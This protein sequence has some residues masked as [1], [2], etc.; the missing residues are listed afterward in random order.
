MSIVIA[1]QLAKSF[2]PQDLFW[3]L[4]FSVARGDRVALVG[5]NGTGKTTLLR[6]L[7]GLEQPTSGRVHRARGLRIGYLPQGASLE[8]DGTLWQAIMAGFEALRAMEARLHELE[9]RMADPASAEEALEAYAPL[10][11]RFEAQGGYS[12]QDQARRVLMGLGFPPEEHEMPVSYLSGGQKTRASLAR[13]LLESPDLLLLDEP[14]NHLDLQAIEWLE[15]YLTTWEGTVVLV[16]HDRYFMDR[17]AQRVWELAFGQIEVYSGNYSHFVQQRAERHE[18]RSKEYQAQQEMVA[19]QEEYIQRNIAGQLHRQAKGRLKRLE[20]F[21]EQELLD[22]PRE[23]RTISLRFQDPLRSGDKVLWTQDLVVGYERDDPL[24]HCPDLDLRRGECVALLGPNGS[25]KTTLLKTLLGQVA[26]LA[27]HAR[28]GASLKI[29]YFAQVHSDLDPEKSPLDAILEVKNLPLAEARNFLARFLFR[30]DDV[31]K[32]IGDLSGG[33][34]SRVA[35]AR[36]VLERANFLLLDEPTNHLDIASQEILEDVM[37]EYSGTILL[38]THDRYLVDRLAS[39]LWLI[40]E[41]QR[42]LEVFE[43]SWAEYQEVRA[44]ENPVVAAEESK[45]KRSADGRQRR[46]QARTERSERDR[47]RREE[48]ARRQQVA[49]LE[50]E[51]QRLEHQVQALQGEIGEASARQEAMRVYEL[52]TLYREIESQLHE[53]L[54]LWAELAG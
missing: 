45:E 12:Y 5:A 9:A 41:G 31:F 29:G 11:E 8:G 23:E 32:R 10:R 16:A 36:L 50:A 1:E 2:G 20:R 4:S 27:G 15:G 35:L 19:R 7:A 6:I 51:I 42:T 26:P 37:D 38:V 28:L 48:E 34:R 53:R 40:D 18:R 44:R 22:R 30:G 3:D 25:G 14:T 39:Q 17:V 43:G 52:G 49:E 13:L 21:K 54:D 33:E 24:F 47:A 46:E